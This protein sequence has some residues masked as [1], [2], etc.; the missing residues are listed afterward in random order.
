MD[1]KPRILVVDDEADFRFS[2]SVAL[3]K[4]GCEVIEAGDGEEALSR[5]QEFRR[6]GKGFDLLLTDLRMPFLCGLDLLEALKDLGIDV[7][8][9]A[10]TGYGDDALRAQLFKR[11]CTEILEK[12]FEP[13]DLVERVQKI[14]VGFVIHGGGV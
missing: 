4:A 3:R 5:F 1:A 6:S 12:P 2:A 13:A 7:P 11:D 9:I 14:L 10:V 8:V